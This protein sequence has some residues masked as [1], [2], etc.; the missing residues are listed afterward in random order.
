MKFAVIVG[1]AIN[2]LPYIT[3]AEDGYFG[4]LVEGVHVS[5]SYIYFGSC[6]AQKSVFV[7]FLGCLLNTLNNL[8]SFPTGG[9]ARHSLRVCKSV[10]KGI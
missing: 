9:N 1:F 6:F 10:C 5:L 3:L 4:H 7:V 2:M 8:F